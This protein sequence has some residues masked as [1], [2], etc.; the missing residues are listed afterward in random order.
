MIAI[1]FSNP[2]PQHIRLQHRIWLRPHFRLLAHSCRT[3]LAGCAHTAASAA[4]IGVCI[5]I[6]A[7]TA[8]IV[9]ARSATD[10]THSIDACMAGLTEKVA[11]SAIVNVCQQIRAHAVAIVEALIATELTLSIGACHAGCAHIAASTTVV[12]V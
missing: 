6:N 3:Y 4:I 12:S 7:R 2:F 10:L 9:E 8:A 5:I 11:S 1:R